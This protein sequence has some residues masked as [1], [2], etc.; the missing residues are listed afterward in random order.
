MYL[1][2]SCSLGVGS[3]GHKSLVSVFHQGDISDKSKSKWLS[4][5]SRPSLP[6]PKFLEKLNPWLPSCEMGPVNGGNQLLYLFL[7]N[8]KSYILG[9]A[10]LTMNICFYR[11]W[12]Q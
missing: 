4:E 5:D 7:V 1:G 9:N 12:E 2:R 3:L 11:L 8:Y 6:L 10:L